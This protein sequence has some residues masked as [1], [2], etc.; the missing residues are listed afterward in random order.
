LDKIIICRGKG[1]IVGVEK[2][3]FLKVN[4]LELMH[5]PLLETIAS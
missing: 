1:I 4:A 3:N 2:K 5:H